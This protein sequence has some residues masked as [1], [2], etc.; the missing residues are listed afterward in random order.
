[1]V[2]FYLS[3]NIKPEIAPTI[4]TS[5]LLIEPLLNTLNMEAMLTPWQHN[6]KFVPLKV[7]KANGALL[8][9]SR[10]LSL[11]LPKLFPV[12]QNIIDLI[13]LKIS[14][15]GQQRF[16]HQ[17]INVPDHVTGE[18]NNDPEQVD[19]I[20]R[21]YKNVN[22]VACGVEGLVVVGRAVE[23]FEQDAQEEE[24]HDDKSGLELKGL[25]VDVSAI[26]HD[27]IVQAETKDSN[28]S[29]VDNILANVIPRKSCYTKSQQDDCDEEL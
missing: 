8:I 19:E 9:D 21:N 4:G 16:S 25:F 12:P 5:A 29:Q 13:S 3:N 18:G 20:Q 11:N 17:P 14:H 6:T 7:H 26:H 15:I 28:S 22:D 24:K 2:E 10:F 1:M 27:K 23:L